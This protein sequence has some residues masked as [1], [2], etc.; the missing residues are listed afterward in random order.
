MAVSRFTAVEIVA[1][2][3]RW[4]PYSN[5]AVSLCKA[6]SLY[7]AASLYKAVTIAWRGW[8]IALITGTNKAASLYKAVILL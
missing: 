8:G 1:G 3:H 2:T 4:G 6:V 5:K 7:K